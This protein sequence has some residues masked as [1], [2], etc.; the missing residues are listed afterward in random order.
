MRSL[1]TLM[2]AVLVGV[3]LFVSWVVVLAI[4]HFLFRDGKPDPADGGSVL[5]SRKKP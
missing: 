1:F 4:T 2:D 5:G 3:G